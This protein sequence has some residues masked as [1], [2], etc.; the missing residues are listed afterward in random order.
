MR[1]ITK[2]LREMEKP[3]LSGISPIR[4]LYPYKSFI[5]AEPVSRYNTSIF[6][7][8][9]VRPLSRSGILDSI[10]TSVQVRNDFTFCL[11]KANSQ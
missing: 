6:T 5:S 1:F 7:N 11:K 3:I 9:L 2:I 4:Y 10:Y 8:K